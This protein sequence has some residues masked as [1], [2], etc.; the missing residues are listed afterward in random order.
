MQN[1]QQNSSNQNPAHIKKIISNIDDALKGVSSA[2]DIESDARADKEKDITDDGNM[3]TA[4]TQLQS[5]L[6]D[7]KNKISEYESKIKKDVCLLLV[8]RLLCLEGT[9]KKVLQQ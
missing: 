2:S 8:F 1:P 3:N 7:V 9:K 5:E 6:K 4:L